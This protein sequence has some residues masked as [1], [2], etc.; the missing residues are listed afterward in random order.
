M[1]LL[2]R[3]EEL[4]A[5]MTLV[6]PLIWRGRV[7]LTAGTVLAASDVRT[8]ASKFPNITVKIGAPELEA[9]VEFEDDSLE[10]EVARTAQQKISE[11]MSKVQAR[12][13]TQASLDGVSVAA[14][15][16][17]ITEM[18]RYLHDSPVSAALL[19]RVM[20][21][22]NYLSGHTGNVFYLSMLLGSAS[23]AYVSCERKRQ[24]LV[25]GLDD[26]VATNLV[27]LGLGA[28]VMDV[29]MMSLTHLFAS[30]KPLTP[31]DWV[32]IRNHPA[33]GAAMLPE[34][35]SATAKTIVRTH[36]ENMEG[37]GYPDSTPGD[38]LHVFTRIVRIADAYDAATAEHVYKEARS[39]IR[40]LW[41]M[42]V[43]PQK[44]FYDPVLMHH[45]SRLIQPFPVGAK[46]WLT[47]RRH[48]VVVRYNRENSLAP[49]IVI[50]FDVRN[51]RLSNRE[52]EGP[53]LLGAD[54]EVRAAK[55]RDEDLSF[56]YQEPEQSTHRSRVG[57]WPTLFEAAFP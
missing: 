28:M 34:E 17:S 26:K 53:M 19:D 36:H 46:I 41:D 48:A 57:V 3:G 5:G 30:D 40:V 56:L 35:F 14:I 49:W 23:Q 1:P 33:A 4:Q 22:G 10:R 42:S 25:R 44:R 6:E 8:L 16:N 37:S 51:R 27:P 39:P 24:S 9:A 45:F 29:G 13:R 7:M 47:D 18:L 31:D 38:K 50:A 21:D 2:L 11:C 32:A 43:G 20:S 52:I 54:R 12:F 55:F 15:H